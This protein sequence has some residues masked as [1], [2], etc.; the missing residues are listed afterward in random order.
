LK[1]G[2]D[3]ENIDDEIARL[4]S[5]SEGQTPE[6]DDKVIG[7]GKQEKGLI[8]ILQQDLKGKSEKIKTLESEKE[9]IRKEERLKYQIR[10][11]AG[12]L[13]PYDIE[14]TTK[15]FYEKY[16][17]DE[18]KDGLIIR[19]RLSGNPIMEEGKFLNVEEAFKVWSQKN[20]WRF[21]SLSQG[22]AGI[23]G[24]GRIDDGI[25]WKRVNSGDHEYIQKNREKIKA[26]AGF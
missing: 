4:Q 12:K 16:E 18:G 19:D 6:I 25:D 26:K 24:D 7:K 1:V 9:F 14:E 22:G 3:I 13:T 10:S 17:F 20:L 21:K 23:G 11:E 15:V 2:I 8:S 5:I